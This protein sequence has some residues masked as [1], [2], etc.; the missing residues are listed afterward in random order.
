[1]NRVLA[2]L[3]AAEKSFSAANPA[4]KPH[5]NRDLFH[6]VLFYTCGEL[7]KERIPEHA[8]VADLVGREP[9][10]KG[11]QAEAGFEAGKHGFEELRAVAHEDANPVAFGDAGR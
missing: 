5:W 9:A 10:V 4:M 1:M 7:V 8:P 6:E 3:D 2:V 11:D